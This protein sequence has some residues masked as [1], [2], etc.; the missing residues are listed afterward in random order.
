MRVGA[1]GARQ[2]PA[3]WDMRACVNCAELSYC[4][5]LQV[6]AA[7]ARRRAT[8][9]WRKW[10][11]RCGPVWRRLACE[12][13]ARDASGA[14]DSGARHPCEQRCQCGD[15]KTKAVEIWGLNYVSCV[16]IGPCGRY[17]CVVG[18]AST[19]AAIKAHCNDFRM[20]AW[21][22]LSALPLE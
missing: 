10:R 2:V 18:L 19:V 13:G 20:S 22:E 9:S 11:C 16:R 5:A 12:G 21:S 1:H 6:D 3:L 7:P 8:A 14:E 15:V 4:A 17:V